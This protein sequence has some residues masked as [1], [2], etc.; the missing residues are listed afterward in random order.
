MISTYCVTLLSGLCLAAS[1]LAKEEAPAL[2]VVVLIGDSIRMGYAPVVA[3]KLKG[4]AEVVTAK[5]NG[6]DSRN[7]LKNL[8]AWAVAP[9]PAVIHFNAGLHDL[10]ADKMTGTHQVELDAYRANLEKIVKRLEAETSARLIFATTTP[11]IDDRHK[12]A[13]PFSREEAD[14]EAYNRAAL[15]IMKKSPQVEVDDLHALAKGLGPGSMTADGVHF[16]KEGSVALG[17]QVASAIKKA[18]GQSSVTREATCR[19][20]GAAPAID[21]KLDDPAWAGAERIDRFSAFWKGEEVG[22]KTVARLVWDEEALYFA[23]TMT[24]GELRA[25]GVKRNDFLWEGDVFE[26]FFKPRADGPEYYEF[27]ANPRSVIFETAIPKRGSDF[28]KLLSQPPS[29]MRVAAVVDG[30]LDRPGDRDRG[31]SVE[32]RIPWSAFAMT[33]GR[34]E[35]G[36]AWLFALCRYDYGPEGTEPVLMSS[37]PLTRGNYHRYEDYGRLRFEGPRR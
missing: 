32:G 33:G 22:P 17:E 31:W 30:T 13:K 35:P 2:P 15:A 1:P 10:K 19:W 26:L 28:L 4:V 29:G 36:A 37:A 24:D 7:V 12:A 6:G 21:G 25:H 20:A 11:V 18:L 27:Q 16:T 23:A 34:P 14:V 8:D 5:E 3:E 9:K